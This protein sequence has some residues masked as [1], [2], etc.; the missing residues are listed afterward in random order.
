MNRGASLSPGQ[1]LVPQVSPGQVEG[2]KGDS[3]GLQAR[4]V[5]LSHH[6][7]R[8]WLGI[9]LQVRAV[10]VKT[11]LQGDEPAALK[12]SRGDTWS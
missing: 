8:P 12:Q 2:R 11:G 10:Q 3:P 5:L 7:G 9:S 1:M 6:S 4:Y